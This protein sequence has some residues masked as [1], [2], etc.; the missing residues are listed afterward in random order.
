VANCWIVLTILGYAHLVSVVWIV[1]AIWPTNFLWRMSCG[2]CSLRMF[3][4]R[5]LDAL[6]GL[7]VCM[8]RNLA[9]KN[10]YSVLGCQV[11]GLEFH[12]QR[13]QRKTATRRRVR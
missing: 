5:E 6:L 9:A 12:A 8:R 1:C 11:V 2:V 4:K 3:V 13:S 7:G 10:A